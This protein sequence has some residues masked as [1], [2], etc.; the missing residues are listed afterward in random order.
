MCA[1]FH[2]TV[3]YEKYKIPAWHVGNV[4]T[5]KLFYVEC[6]VCWHCSDKVVKARISQVG[7]R[8]RWNP[9]FRE[10]LGVIDGSVQILVRALAVTQWLKGVIGE[11]WRKAW[12]DLIRNFK[13]DSVSFIGRERN[14]GSKEAGRPERRSLK[15]FRW[16]T[17]W[18][19]LQS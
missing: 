5:E 9:V 7:L 8:G 15:Y 10:S 14:R 17:W 4:K 6:M 18:L 12:Y 19:G 3:N 2:F 16:E 13:E 11:S 1:V